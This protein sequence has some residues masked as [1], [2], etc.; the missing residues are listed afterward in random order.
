MNNALPLLLRRLLSPG[1]ATHATPH[2]QRAHTRYQ[3]P[4]VHLTLEGQRYRT[5]DWSLGGFRIPAFHRVLVRGDRLAG[6]VGAIAYAPPGPVEL[7][8][9]HASDDCVGFRIIEIAP[10]SFLAMAGLKAH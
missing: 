2:E 10:Q 1:A 9:A 6:T 3:S 5:L 8:V 4:A 7:E